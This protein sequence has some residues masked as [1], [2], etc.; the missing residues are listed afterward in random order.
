MAHEEKKQREIAW[1]RTA[2]RRKP[3]NRPFLLS[4]TMIPRQGRF[5]HPGSFCI[6]EERG[7]LYVRR[8]DIDRPCITRT[9]ILDRVA[10]VCDIA[11]DYFKQIMAIY[12][13]FSNKGNGVHVPLVYMCVQLYIAY[14][15]SKHITLT[16]NH[17]YAIYNFANYFLTANFNEGWAAYARKDHLPI[18]R[19]VD[20]WYKLARRY[21]R[22]ELKQELKGE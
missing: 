20:N 22:K 16:S 11:Q 17:C 5:Y 14:L 21:K 19:L 6:R 4:G 8:L 10:F 12:K 7:K 1:V 18:N 15:D 2:R 13:L 9:D 3:H